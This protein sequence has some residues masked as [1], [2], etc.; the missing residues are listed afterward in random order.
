MD[1]P[2]LVWPSHEFG[3]QILFEM[4][5]GNIYSALEE[6]FPGET[7]MPDMSTINNLPSFTKIAVLMIRDSLL[8]SCS[9]VDAAI[10]MKM[11]L[12][13]WNDW[14]IT[15]ATDFFMQSNNPVIYL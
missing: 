4:M 3:G 11:D 13:D 14:T 6:L 2:N 8:R 1:N 5:F 7:R 12:S 15:Y 9:I 10:G